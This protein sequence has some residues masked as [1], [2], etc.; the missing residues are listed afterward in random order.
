MSDYEGMR[1]MSREEIEKL[2]LGLQMRNA[3]PPFPG[4]QNVKRKPDL[5]LRVKLAAAKAEVDTLSAAV[6]NKAMS[7]ILQHNREAELAKA[8]RRLKALEN[9]SE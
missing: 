2:Q 1:P 5:V 4:I 6:E 3:I 9:P 7:G 8:V